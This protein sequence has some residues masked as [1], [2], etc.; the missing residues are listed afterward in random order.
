MSYCIHKEDKV[1]ELV[2]IDEA[3]DILLP[4]ITPAAGESLSLTEAQGRIVWFDLLRTGAGNVAVWGEDGDSSDVTLYAQ[5]LEDNVPR[6]CKTDICQKY[7]LA[8]ELMCELKGVS[9]LATQCTLHHIVNQWPPT[10]IDH[11]HAGDDGQIDDALVQCFQLLVIEFPQGGRQ[12]GGKSA[13]DTAQFSFDCLAGMNVLDAH[14]G[15][16]DQQSN[17]KI[18]RQ[19][20]FQ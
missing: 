1:R 4:L 5:A 15:Q 17:R 16:C 2:T 11:A 9:D 13:F 8:G 12:R 3:L 14:L 7:L 18:D 19:Y 6:G 10:G 20:G